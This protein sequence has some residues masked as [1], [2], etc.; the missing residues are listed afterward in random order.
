MSFN[1]LT[2]FHWTLPKNI[3]EFGLPIPELREETLYCTCQIH[4]W[5]YFIKIQI[6]CQWLLHY[7]KKYGNHCFQLFHN[8][9]LNIAWEYWWMWIAHINIEGKT[10]LHMW[11][12]FLEVFLKFQTSWQWQL[13][14]GKYYGNHCFSIDWH[15]STEHWLK[16]LM[17]LDCPYQNWEKTIYCTCQIYS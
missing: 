12:T 14:Y 5:K 8:L 13:H 2:S 6:S 15:L 17:N 10:L 11:N 4:S 7:G 16:R 9:S 1:C 3:D